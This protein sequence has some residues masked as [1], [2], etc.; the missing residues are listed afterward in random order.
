[1]SQALAVVIAYLLGSIPFGYLAGRAQGVDIRTLGSGNIGTTNV[2][3]ILGRRWGI[4]VL[5]ADVGKGLVAVLIAK[6]LTGG[7]WPVIAAVAAVVGHVAPVWLRFKGGKG[8]AVAGGAIIGLMPLASLILLG[9]W[10]I[11]FALS[12]YVSAASIAGA[13]AFTPVAWALGYGWQYIAF[14]AVV[15][16]V[17]IV[18]HRSNIRRLA[19]GK[20]L[21]VDLRRRSR[22]G[23][24]AGA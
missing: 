11:V 6:E 14:A 2:F 22:P 12:R 3:R 7:V 24:E 21:R 5:V 18:R 17:V 20:E 16:L 15:S 8:V 19:T 23:P 13:V 4:A 10:I 1:M 9:V